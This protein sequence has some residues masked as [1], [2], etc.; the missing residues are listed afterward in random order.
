MFFSLVVAEWIWCKKASEK[1][2]QSFN[3]FVSYQI[4]ILEVYKYTS[5]FVQLFKNKDNFFWLTICFSEPSHSFHYGFTLKGNYLL[6]EEQMDSFSPF[7]GVLA[8]LSA[9]GLR[10]HPQWERRQKS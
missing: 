1:E 4:F 8:I 7:Y 9:K 6:L 2:I 10:V 3:S 5:I